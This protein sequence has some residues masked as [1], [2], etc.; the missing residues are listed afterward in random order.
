MGWGSFQKKRNQKENKTKYNRLE[1]ASD[2][3]F[4]GLEKLQRSVTWKILCKKTLI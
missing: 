2:S 4:K 1:L 3:V